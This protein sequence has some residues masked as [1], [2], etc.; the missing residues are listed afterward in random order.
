MEREG[1]DEELALE[2]GLEGLG[3]AGEQ[4]ARGGERLRQRLRDGREIDAARVL[5][6]PAVHPEHARDLDREQLARVAELEDLGLLGLEPRAEHLDR[7]GVRVGRSVGDLSPRR[8]RTCAQLVEHDPPR[9]PIDVR[10]GSGRAQQLAARGREHEPFELGER[11]GPPPLVSQLERQVL[12][13]AFGPGPDQA[14]PQGLGRGRVQ[15][16]ERE[17]CE[18]DRGAAARP[19]RQARRRHERDRRR[20][21][22][23]VGFAGAPR[24]CPHAALVLRVGWLVFAAS[25][26]RAALRPRVLARPRGGE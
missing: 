9:Q 19:D 3:R 1:G 5:E 26:G 21:V 6:G 7:A 16:R 24:A 2:R 22:G 23:L 8:G 11:S 15:A 18:G 17:A 13:Q 4:R 14:A 12:A 25:S 10:L 20:L